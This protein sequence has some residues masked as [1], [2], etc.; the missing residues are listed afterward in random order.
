MRVTVA[1]VA[2]RAAPQGRTA[3][4]GRPPVSSRSR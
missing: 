1:A 4:R 3:V 2:M